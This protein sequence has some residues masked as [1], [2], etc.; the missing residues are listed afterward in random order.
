MAFTLPGFSTV[1]RE[2]IELTTGFT[3]NVNAE[4]RVGAL[5]ETIVVTGASPVVDVQN[6]GQ[7]T[8]LSR[9][10]LDTLPT[11]KAFRGFAALT[12]GASIPLGAG[13]QD[14]GGNQGELYAQFIVHGGRGSDQRMTQDG[15]QVHGL[16]AGAGGR[17]FFINEAGVQET[18]L[19]TGGMS[20][21]SETGG[22]QVNVVPKDGGNSWRAYF[23]G[24]YANGGMQADNVDDA[25]RARGVTGTPSVKHIYDWGGGVG[26]PIRRDKIWFY[27]AHRWWGAANNVAG[28]FAYFNQTQGTPFYTPDTSQPAYTDNFQR[29][30]SLRVT[31]QPWQQHK[32]TVSRTTSTTATAS[33]AW[34]AARA[35]GRPRQPRCSVRTGVRDPGDLELSGQQPPALPGRRVVSSQR[36]VRRPRARRLR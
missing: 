30:N 19:Q 15:M 1:R 27:T 35:S 18:T 24:A 31:F 6:A 28:P 21:E 33:S 36:A 7:Q 9:E 17:S 32:F 26:G 16:E 3:A 22:V 29:D 23:N 13:L 8:V 34:T 10:V 12:L 25:L 5:E 11:A 4:L 2:G 14:V 20:A